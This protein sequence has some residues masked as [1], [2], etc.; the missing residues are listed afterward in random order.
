MSKLPRPYAHHL[1]THALLIPGMLALAASV[2]HASG[3]DVEL[4]RAFFDPQSGAFP[5]RSSRALELIG[6]RLAKSAIAAIWLGVLAAAIAAP[7]VD[8]LKPHRAVLWTTALAMGL[9]PAIVVLLKEINDHHCP[10]DLKQFGGYADYA[11]DWFVAHVDAGHCFPA[12]HAAGGFSLIAL[13]FAGTAAGSAR[14]RALGLAGALIAGS[15]FGLVRIAQGAHFLSHNLWSAAIDW[16][17][18]ALVFAPLLA[19]SCTGVPRY[20]ER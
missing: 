9:G 8:A 6:H 3:L 2:A 4:S 18:A 12:G 14:I 5:A 17:A 7:I 1:L 15:V 16:C 11:A 20:A 13:L 19:R 10:W